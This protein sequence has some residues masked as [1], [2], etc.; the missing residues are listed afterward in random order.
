M[1]EEDLLELQKRYE[2]GKIKEED[3]SKE[4]EKNLKK[5]YKKQIEEKKKNLEDYKIKIAKYLKKQNFS[6]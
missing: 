3:L 4:E 1:E 6:A 5:L 2:S